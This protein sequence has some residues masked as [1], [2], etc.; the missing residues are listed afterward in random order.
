MQ[1]SHITIGSGV[2]RPQFSLKT[3]LLLT[4]LACAALGAAH[5]VKRYGE[6]VAVPSHKATKSVML[7]GRLIRLFGP[8]TLRWK[9]LV[10]SE[11]EPGV[12]MHGGSS[13]RAWLFAYPVSIEEYDLPGR[14]PPGG[15][16]S[17]DSDLWSDVF[18]EPGEY[19]VTLLQ[20]DAPDESR[21]TC[22]YVV[23]P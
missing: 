9:V 13:S 1:V 20:V 10:D 19:T 14:S 16:T 17:A 23:T 7:K 11:E 22:K 12:R 4:T 15:D 3:L 21:A 18:P 8:K 5:L 6:F 2:R